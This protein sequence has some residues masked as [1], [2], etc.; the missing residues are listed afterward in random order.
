MKTLT[1]FSKITPGFCTQPIDNISVYN[2]CYVSKTLLKGILKQYGI[3][4]AVIILLTYIYHL[5]GQSIGNPT[6]TLNGIVQSECKYFYCTVGSMYSQK[7]TE[8]KSLINR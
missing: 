8:V 2:D 7:I 5:L 4:S 3:L 6:T 1:T